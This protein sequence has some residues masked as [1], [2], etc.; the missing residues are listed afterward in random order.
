MKNNELKAD[1]K[2]MMSLVWEDIYDSDDYCLVCRYEDYEIGDAI[3]YC[4]LCSISLHLSC[5][6]LE[7]VDKKKDFVC[8][9]CKAFGSNSL[10]IECAL[11]QQLGGALKPI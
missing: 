3:I 4:G 5:Y 8:N 10:M 7:E 1:I 2:G 6:G 11:C 9:N